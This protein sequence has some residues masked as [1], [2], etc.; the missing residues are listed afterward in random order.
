VTNWRPK[1][2]HP[3]NLSGGKS[4]NVQTVALGALL[5]LLLAPQVRKFGLNI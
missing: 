2:K 5:Y 3:K 4:M 1:S